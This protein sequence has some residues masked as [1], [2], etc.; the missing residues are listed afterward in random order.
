MVAGRNMENR[1]RRINV[2]LSA[3]TVGI[4]YFASACRILCSVCKPSLT[5]S[6]RIILSLFPS[7]SEVNELQLCMVIILLLYVLCRRARKSIFKIFGHAMSHAVSR[8]SV[9]AERRVWCL[10]GPCKI[11]GEKM[12]L[13]RAFCECFEFRSQCHSICAPCSFSFVYHWH[14][15]ILATACWLTN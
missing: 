10:A 8:R 13:G 2:I 15:I 3:H 12:V 9:T 6:I 1:W 7:N 5:Q 14:C 11:C 4:F